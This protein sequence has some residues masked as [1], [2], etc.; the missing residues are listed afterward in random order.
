LFPDALDLLKTK[1]GIR[2]ALNS[3]G[4]FN[5]NSPIARAAFLRGIGRRKGH[6]CLPHPHISRALMIGQDDGSALQV[7]VM[8][9]F[10]VSRERFYRSADDL[11]K[12]FA[13]FITEAESDSPSKL[14]ADVRA[15]EGG[16]LV[17]CTISHRERLR[18]MGYRPCADCGDI[19]QGER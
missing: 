12:A 17:M 18:V 14:F 11:A 5:F 6:Q 4:P 10:G 8:S 9:D 13:A 19:F 1:N 7:T 2:K 16:L 15:V 3:L